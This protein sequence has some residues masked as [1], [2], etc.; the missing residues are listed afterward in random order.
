GK[1][2]G[3]DLYQSATEGAQKL[4]S[5]PKGQIG[6]SIAESAGN[7]LNEATPLLGHTGEL[8]AM[9]EAGLPDAAQTK[10]LV[11]G[12]EARAA[13][14]TKA[15]ALAQPELE[16]IRAAHDAGYVLTP[17]AAQ[18]GLGARIAESAAGSAR[19]A[20]GLSARNAENT[21]RLARA[22]V[23]LPDDVPATPEATAGIRKTAGQAYAA[24][25]DVGPFENDAQYGKDLDTIAAPIEKAAVD[26]PDSKLADHPLLSTIEGLRTDGPVNTGS[27]I[28]MVKQLR[29]KSDVAFRAGDKNLGNQ[30]RAVAGA[31]DNSMDRALGRM[32]DAGNDPELTGAV[33]KYRAARVTIAKTYLLDDAMDGKPGEVNAKVYGRAL[34]SGTPLTGPALQI[35]NFAKQFGDEGLAAKKGRS[36]AVGP[37]YHDILLGALLHAPTAAGAMV[38]RPVTRAFLGSDFMQ[39]RMAGSK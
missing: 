1:P 37:T 24:V 25:Q 26:Y 17:K 31:V 27:A 36:G 33:D 15:A 38:A 20:Q 4:I 34:D 18:A 19:L 11:P 29:S 5:Q 16:G 23:G 14:A 28:E 35:A 10:M 2:M 30:Y 39:R 3:D 21:A 9:H 32:A 22:D 13:A 7:A 6:Q 12:S 8:G